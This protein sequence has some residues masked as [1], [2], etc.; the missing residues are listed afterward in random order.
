MFTHV[1]QQRIHYVESQKE[2]P[3]NGKGSRGHAGSYLLNRHSKCLLSSNFLHSFCGSRARKKPQNTVLAW[4]Q[5]QCSCIPRVPGGNKERTRLERRL[6]NTL[7]S[8]TE[9]KPGTMCQGSNLARKPGEAALQIHL[10][11]SGSK[12]SGFTTVWQ[13]RI[14]LHSHTR[15]PAGLYNAVYSVLPWRR[16]LLQED[17]FVTTVAGATYIRLKDCFNRSLYK[18]YRVSIKIKK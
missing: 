5:E 2:G 13:D 16:Y 3:N 8:A 12:K 18:C 6:A 4:W 11:N 7:L 14:Y 15:N 1:H 9:T 17:F 10:R